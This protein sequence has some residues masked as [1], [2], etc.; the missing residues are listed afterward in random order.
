MKIY[1]IRALLWGR[2][3]GRTISAYPMAQFCFTITRI[4]PGIYRA[5]YPTG[6]SAGTDSLARAK[7]ECSRVWQEILNQALD[8]KDEI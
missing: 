4:S 2:R 7:S 6:S 8:L 3:N 5:T 1:T